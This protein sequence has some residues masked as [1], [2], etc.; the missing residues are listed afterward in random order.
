MIQR[1]GCLLRTLGFTVLTLVVLIVAFASGYATGLAPA[2]SLSSVTPRLNPS[3]PAE[4]AEFWEAWRILKAHYYG[5][6]P[7][8]DQL[9]PAAIRGLV[10]S[11]GD[12]HTAY[13]DAKHAAIFQQDLEGNFEGIG[14][15]VRINEQ[16]HL[17]IV[18]PLD[19]SPAQRAGLLPGDIV[20]EANG[21][22]IKN[23]NVLEAVT[24]IR[25]P[26]G[27]TV[28]LKIQRVGEAQPFD[29]DIVRERINIA[30]VQFEMMDDN[31]AYIKLTDFSANAPGQFKDALKKLLDQHPT[32]L[33]LDL[34]NKPGGFLQ[35]AVDIAG[36]FLPNKVILIERDKDGNKR[37]HRSSGRG[38]AADI[39]LVLLVDKGSA[40]ASEILAGAIQDH[41][42]GTLIGET[43]FGKGSV[44]LSNTL[45]DGSALRVTTAHWFTPLDREINGTGIKPDIVVARTPEDLRAGSDPQLERAIQFLRTGK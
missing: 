40:S 20:L 12:P 30:V 23:M 41:N 8:Q 39:P 18:A 28:R 10:S 4:F 34:R 43:T 7:T 35:V 27:T 37:V 44:Q 1:L 38:I 15:T 24:L 3:Q 42:R 14:A 33:I 25:G 17:V 31:I 13:V 5:K 11:L 22:P 9:A 36:Q 21:I 32:G 45:S 16:G 26:R 2:S 6:L 29:V 19:N